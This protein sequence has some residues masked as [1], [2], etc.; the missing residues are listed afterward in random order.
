[1]KLIAWM[2]TSNTLQTRRRVFNDKACQWRMKWLEITSGLVSSFWRVP[3][4]LNFSP[5]C[6]LESKISFT[7]AIMST[8]YCF[9]SRLTNK[10]FFISFW[11]TCRE[12]REVACNVKQQLI[13]QTEKSIFSRLLLIASTTVCGYL[14]TCPSVNHECHRFIMRSVLFFILLHYRMPAH[15]FPWRMVL[16][17][18]PWWYAAFF[19]GDPLW[20]T[21]TWLLSI[22]FRVSPVSRT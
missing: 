15:Q 10:I 3:W 14:L 22:I 9:F 11:C 8:V 5:T 6:L 17:V 16:P 13:H 18:F 7:I 20:H 2:K 4:I 12:K 21:I 19:F 1:M